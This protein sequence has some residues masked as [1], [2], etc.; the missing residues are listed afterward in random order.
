MSVS[1]VGGSSAPPVPPKPE[2][3]VDS[4]HDAD[5]DDAATKAPAQAAPAPGTG[6]QV[7]KS[8]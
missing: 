7:D 8:A 1:A 5:G 3:K 4:P 2:A 6:A